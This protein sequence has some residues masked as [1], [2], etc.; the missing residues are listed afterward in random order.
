MPLQED[1]WLEEM[2]A[3]IEETE[4]RPQPGASRPPVWFSSPRRRLD[5]GKEIV[6]ASSEPEEADGAPATPAGDKPQGEERTTPSKELNQV[7]TM[8]IDTSDGGRDQA[9]TRFQDL[10]A[11]ESASLN[12]AF[13][14]KLPGG[15]ISGDLPTPMEVGDIGSPCLSLGV[16]DQE[17]LAPP[18]PPPRS[19]SGT[20]RQSRAGEPCC[21]RGSDR[22][23]GPRV[24]PEHRR[25]QGRPSP[26]SET[27]V[28]SRAPERRREA[29]ARTPRERGKPRPRLHRNTRSTE[30]IR[31]DQARQRPRRERT[32]QRPRQ[33]RRNPE[34]PRQVHA[35][36]HR[37]GVRCS[38]GRR[39]FQPE[40]SRTVSTGSG[41]GTL[42]VRVRNVPTPHRNLPDPPRFNPRMAERFVVAVSTGDDA[43]R[44]V[45]P[46]RRGVERAHTWVP[47]AIRRR[48][49]AMEEPTTRRER[50]NRKWRIYLDDD[51]PQ[52]RQSVPDSAREREVAGLGRIS[53]EVRGLIDNF[54]KLKA[55]CPPAQ[56]RG[57]QAPQPPPAL[58]IPDEDQEDEPVDQEL[59][60][61]PQF[62]RDGLN[63]NGLRQEFRQYLPD[64]GVHYNLYLQNRPGPVGN[65]QH[66]VVETQIDP[67]A[68]QTLDNFLKK[69]TF[70]RQHVGDG[71]EDNIT[72]SFPPHPVE[73]IPAEQ[74]MPY[75]WE[76]MLSQR[77][78]TDYYVP[79]RP[80]EANPFETGK[81][82]R[83]SVKEVSRLMSVENPPAAVVFHPPSAE[84]SAYRRRARKDSLPI[85]ESNELL[86]KLRKPLFLQQLA[87]SGIT[88]LTDRIQDI[89]PSKTILLHTTKRKFMSGYHMRC[90]RS[91]KDTQAITRVYDAM[92][93]G[94][95]YIVNC[96]D[97]TTSLNSLFEG[98]SPTPSVASDSYREPQL[99]CAQGAG[100]AI[101]YSKGFELFDQ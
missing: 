54:A 72:F 1:C 81:R 79:P 9:S 8:S 51:M 96:R 64:V 26:A 55:G 77:A 69:G 7:R 2:T 62:L 25:H 29:Y 32:P 52:V 24:T 44:T 45:T 6:K 10:P 14:A 38:D 27:T 57:P 22:P 50:R 21:R 93:R 13:T 31:R 66:L 92:L 34:G 23:P 80:V 33:D 74:P 101:D 58:A 86:T 40:V 90:K 95:K 4:L 76:E 41:G 28:S 88:V 56:R 47:E 84:I 39:R 60:A 5:T 59:Y 35:G 42:Q 70:Y 91:W 61:E 89:L 18:A 68:Q 20:A 36:H 98:R 48:P 67:A 73:V 49:E 17:D 87:D 65:E 11:A 75:D 46:C 19:S 37:S 100:D 30:P 12:A 16:S 82:I 71:M 97:L 63:I 53:A 83:F 85:L 78:I 15:T 43:V 99:P 3:A 94:C